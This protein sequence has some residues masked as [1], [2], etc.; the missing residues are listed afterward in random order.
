MAVG[1][2]E[3]SFVALAAPF[4]GEP[5]AA[6]SI[7]L[8]LRTS[9]ASRHAS[10]PCGIVFSFKLA[11]PVHHQQIW[12]ALLCQVNV[13]QQKDGQQAADSD[14]QSFTCNRHTAK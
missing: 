2:G 4:I 12:C 9:L 13:L 11:V 1:I 3:A 14:Y 8:V 10:G 7:S 6:R 5:S